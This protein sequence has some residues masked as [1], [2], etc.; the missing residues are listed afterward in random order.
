MFPTLCSGSFGNHVQ[1]TLRAFTPPD[2]KA[3]NA[4]TETF[5]PNLDIDKARNI[6]ELGKG[7]ALVC[8]LEAMVC[9]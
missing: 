3:V 4:A 5:G 7:E 6:A 1:H 8:F 2:P 9:P